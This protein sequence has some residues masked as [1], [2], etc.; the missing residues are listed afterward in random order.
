MILVLLTGFAAAAGGI[1]SP[2]FSRIFSD[3]IL[4]GQ[5]TSWY[6]VILYF[7][8]AVIFY[9]LIAMVIH[10][11]LLIR[12]T[13]KLAVQSNAAYMYHLLQLPLSFFSRRRTGDLANRQNT[14]DTIAETLIGQLAPL[15][16]N[17]LML[18]FY[19]VVMVQYSTLLTGIGFAAIVLNLLVARRVGTIRREISATQYRSQA[20][21]DS[22]TVSGIDMIESIKATGS[23]TGY[24]ERWSGFHASV[25]R[26]QVRFNE[27]AKYLL[28]LPSL[29]QKISDCIVLVT[30]C[31][32]II[33][34][35]FTAGILIAFLQFLQALASPVND[36]LEAGENLQEMGSS[37][38][39]VRDVMDY[40]KEIVQEYVKDGLTSVFIRPLT[41]LGYANEHW[42]EIGYTTDDF[43]KFYR[44][45][46]H[47]IIECNK[48]GIY[49]S[50]GHAT[51]FLQKI[52]GH[53][54]G[55][56]MELRSPC[57]ASTGQ[58]AYY[59]DGNVYTCDEGR[60]LAEMGNPFFKLGNV[61]T[62]NYNTLMESR[63][64]SAICQAS[65]L[66]GLASCSDCVYQPYCGV[67]PVINLA[68]DNN[69][70]ERQ[71]NNYRCRIYKGILDTLFELLKDKEIEEI[72]QS[73][74]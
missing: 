19:L 55:N 9:Q 69:I 27:T 68:L 17:I 25:V 59:Y 23:E 60:M 35:R 37:L 26:A 7:F 8:A 33:E 10:Q 4:S 61:Y 62:D 3:D 2:V 12:S 22:A 70:Y 14:N 20:N 18:V 45:A 49:I 50:E 21:L 72:F 32:L 5:R 34:G 28:T 46:L 44:K 66:E 65:V 64:C 11:T 24:F 67:C 1:I 41:P 52:I 31:W 71:P 13:G 53:F 51:I 16:M 74:V 43:L 63:V 42:D 40:P 38:E 73:W 36:L 6:P 29:I 48:K 58:I 57:G 15:I 30:G 56:Y 39:R 47:E 54:S